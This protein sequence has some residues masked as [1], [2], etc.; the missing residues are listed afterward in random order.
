MTGCATKHTLR[1]QTILEYVSFFK[2][3]R[4]VCALTGAKLHDLQATSSYFL[5]APNGERYPLVG[6]TRASHFDGI[7]LQA[8]QSA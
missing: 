2:S 1:R 5:P 8:T 4:C 6:G 7:Q 3:R